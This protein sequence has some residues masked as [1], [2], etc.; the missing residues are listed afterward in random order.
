SLNLSHTDNISSLY[1]VHLL[2]PRSTLFPYTTLFRSQ[3]LQVDECVFSYSDIHYQDV[4][5]ISAIVN[6]AGADFKL[7]GPTNTMLK[8]HKPVI[9]VCAVR[10]GTG[11]SQTSRKI[12][13]TLM[14]HG[15]KVV[16]IRHP[17]PYGDI[18]AQRV[19]RFATVDDLKKHH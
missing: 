8:S 6:A 19:Q 18:S 15:L 16:A 3:T 5:R 2:P 7:L 11:K 17:M 1:P 12:I 4:M 13:E 14:D 9:S 10:T